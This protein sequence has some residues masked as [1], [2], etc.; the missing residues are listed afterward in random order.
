LVFCDGNSSPVDTP[1]PSEYFFARFAE[2]VRDN[3]TNFIC[4]WQLF[5]RLLDGL[6]RSF[7]SALVRLFWEDPIAKKESDEE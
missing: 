1:H 2:L 4:H 5:L 7:Q 3:T 6:E